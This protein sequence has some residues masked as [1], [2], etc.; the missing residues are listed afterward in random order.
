MIGRRIGEESETPSPEL[1]SNNISTKHLFFLKYWP[2]ITV[3]LSL[4]IPIP[5]A[6][7]DMKLL[8]NINYVA[9]TVRFL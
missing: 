7:K 2:T 9:K 8:R 1:P 5:M 3:A 6:M 4:S